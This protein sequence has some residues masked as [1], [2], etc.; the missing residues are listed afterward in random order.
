MRGYGQRRD[1]FSTPAIAK[2]MS[3]KNYFKKSST[4]EI[5]PVKIFSKRVFFH[6]NL[7]GYENYI[8]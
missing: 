2:M 8:P 5:K 4:I 3:V 1:T 7:L 6:D